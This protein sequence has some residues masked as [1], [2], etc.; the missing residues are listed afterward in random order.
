MSMIQTPS[1]KN[2]ALKGVAFSLRQ[3]FA[4][5]SY[6]VL[7]SNCGRRSL[8]SLRHHSASLAHVF[9]VVGF[10][11]FPLTTHAQQLQWPKTFSGQ[12]DFVFERNEIIKNELSRAKNEGAEQPTTST[13][14]DLLTPQMKKL[15]PLQLRQSQSVHTSQEDVESEVDFSSLGGNIQSVALPDVVRNELLDISEFKEL[16]DV[17]AKTAVRKTRLDTNSFD[18]SPYL[19]RLTLQAVVT[20]P[21]QYAVI[22]QRR[23]KPGERLQLHVPVPISLDDIES[24]LNQHM[25]PEDVLPEDRFKQYQTARKEVLDDYAQQIKTG[26]LKRTQKLSVQLQK[27]ESRRAIL[28]VGE[29]QYDLAIKYAL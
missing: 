22:N 20:S 4:F 3:G 5:L 9:M 25:P 18:F 10:I 16:L 27:I 29:R 14:D 23:Y 19:A 8:R 15:S 2:A 28:K 11:S 24:A 7:V 1:I 12:P 6:G 21:T 17:T 13:L 26:R